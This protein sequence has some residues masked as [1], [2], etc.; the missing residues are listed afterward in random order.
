MFKTTMLQF[1]EEI[2]FKTFEEQEAL[3]FILK[4]VSLSEGVFWYFIA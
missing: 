2:F 4:I 3:E 1:F